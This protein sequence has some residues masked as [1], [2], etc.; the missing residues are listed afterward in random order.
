MGW[1]SAGS[2]SQIQPYPMASYGHPGT[3]AAAT[4]TGFPGQIGSY[5]GPF[6]AQMAGMAGAASGPYAGYSPLTMIGR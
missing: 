5:F 6:A 2:G 1:T 3:V 4:P